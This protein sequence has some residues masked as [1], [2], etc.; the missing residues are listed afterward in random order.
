MRSTGAHSTIWPRYIT[1]TQSL[2]YS[3][4]CRSW[5]M[6]SVVRPYCARRSTNRLS[7]CACTD[8]SSADTGSSATQQARPQDERAG[9][10]HALALPAGQ[11]VGVA[12]GVVA[13]QPDVGEHG[14]H[15]ALH[16]RA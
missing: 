10:V 1:A 2:R 11:F 4:T 7:T 14:A 13:G 5:E 3:T 12:G 8:L 9:E 16:G 15:R 6:N